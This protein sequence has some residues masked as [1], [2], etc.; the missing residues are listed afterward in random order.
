MVTGRLHHICHF[1]LPTRPPCALRTFREHQRYGEAQAMLVRSGQQG[2]AR[3]RSL[4]EGLST[5]AMTTATTY[6]TRPTWRRS[7][8]TG[9]PVQFS[10]K[11]RR[12]WS[13]ET[14]SGPPTPRWSSVKPTTASSSCNS[15]GVS[16]PLGPKARP[17][18]TSAR[19]GGAFPKG[20][21]IVPASHFFEFTG[22]K[23]P[24]VEVAVHQGRR[25]LV[26]SGL[27]PASIACRRSS[28]GSVRPLPRWPAPW[29]FYGEGA[30]F[31]D[32]R[33]H[34]GCGGTGGGGSCATRR[35]LDRTEPRISGT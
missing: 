1:A 29:W 34:V 24:K 18:S 26:L 3:P 20:H 15:V 23:S 21:C 17:S 12:T 14:T 28:V 4:A 7:D 11:P 25:G 13:P 22:T 27:V 16:R 33:E 32:R 5:C 10:R 31:G 6:L 2:L 30:F 19:K 35:V 8:K 9:I